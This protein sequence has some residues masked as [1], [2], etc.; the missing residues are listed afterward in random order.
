MLWAAIQYLYE[1]MLHMLY[2]IRI[3]VSVCVLVWLP[4]LACQQ[5][6]A[7]MVGTRAEGRVKGMPAVSTVSNAHPLAAGRWW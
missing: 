1:Y 3:C 6:A 7:T 2:A 4:L 5:R